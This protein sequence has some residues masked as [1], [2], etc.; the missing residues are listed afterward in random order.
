MHRSAVDLAYVDD[1][2]LYFGTLRRDDD[3]SGTLSRR[4][5]ITNISSRRLLTWYFR[6][7]QNS[8]QPEPWH[9]AFGFL[10]RRDAPSMGSLATREPVKSPNRGTEPDRL[11]LVSRREPKS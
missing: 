9:P 4:L 5:F 10:L 1:D 2:W 3:V 7:K 6:N 8:M 11:S